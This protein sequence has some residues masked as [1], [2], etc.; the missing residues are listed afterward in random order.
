MKNYFSGY[1]RG[2]HSEGCKVCNK[3]TAWYNFTPSFKSKK[4]KFTTKADAYLCGLC[5][6]DY[7]MKLR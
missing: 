5:T 3:T 7:Y 2:M 6:V 1:P 4:F